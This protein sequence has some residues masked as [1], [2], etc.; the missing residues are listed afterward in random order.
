[1]IINGVGCPY[2]GTGTLK[3]LVAAAGIRARSGGPDIVFDR[4]LINRRI[5][6]DCYDFPAW[7]ERWIDEFDR[8]G[9]ND[10]IHLDEHFYHDAWERFSV[11]YALNKKYDQKLKFLIIL[12]DPREVIGHWFHIMGSSGPEVTADSYRNSV[13]K[14]T[15]F[16]YEQA[17]L[18]D[19]KP[20]V[21]DY[22]AFM[23]GEHLKQ[24]FDWF[25]IDTS[26]ENLHKAQGHLRVSRVR[27]DLYDGDVSDILFYQDKLMKMR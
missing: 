13:L 14:I 2:S 25:Q 6:Y 1:M 11:M 15:E 9:Y 4:R 5:P 20:I 24:I 17:D 22:A 7:V 19:D 3:E 27:T 16:L 26:L 21:W 23:R 12:R 8:N 10:Y 18:M